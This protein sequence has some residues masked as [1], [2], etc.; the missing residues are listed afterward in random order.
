MIN[1]LKPH[2]LVVHKYFGKGEV[3]DNSDV[4]LLEVRF[5][6]DVR[7]L[8]KESLISKHLLVKL[9]DDILAGRKK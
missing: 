1:K 3:Y 5:G 2:D 6:S 7:F 4:K 9:D 8:N